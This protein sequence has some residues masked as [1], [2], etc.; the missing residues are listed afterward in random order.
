MD[1]RINTGVYD[2][3][4]PSR[5]LLAVQ[6]PTIIDGD[7]IKDGKRTWRFPKVRGMS[8]WNSRNVL[9]KVHVA[10]PDAILSMFNKRYTCKHDIYVTT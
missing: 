6:A 3:G 10:E 8:V 9:C 1:P 2:L 4:H 7:N 5:H